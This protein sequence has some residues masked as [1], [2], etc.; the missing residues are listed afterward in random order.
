MNI[1]LS[2]Q[3]F[4]LDGSGSI[5][6][7]VFHDEVLR[8]ITEF[9]DLFDIGPDRTRVGVVQYSDRIRH[10]FDLSQYT[11]R[12]SVIKGIDDIE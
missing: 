8:F 1:H 12:D 5:G 7:F 4:L 3:V 6:S 2:F 10:E 11:T 9:V